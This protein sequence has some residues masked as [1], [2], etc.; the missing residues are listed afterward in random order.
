MNQA[1]NLTVRTTTLT[2][3]KAQIVSGGNLDIQANQVSVKE[4]SIAAQGN[5]DVQVQQTLEME[6]GKFQRPG[7]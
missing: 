2:S 5:A 1:G 4:G 6:K 7:I 3:D